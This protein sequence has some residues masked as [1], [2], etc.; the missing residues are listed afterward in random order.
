[1]NTKK[2]ERLAILRIACFWDA[3]LLDLDGGRG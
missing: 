2:L 3:A 1:M